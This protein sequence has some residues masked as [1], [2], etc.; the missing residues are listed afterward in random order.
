MLQTTLGDT[1][2]AGISSRIFVG[3]LLF[4]SACAGGGSTT[5]L[6]E[7]ETERAEQLEETEGDERAMVGTN[8]GEM[9]GWMPPNAEED[10]EM[11]TEPYPE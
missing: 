4:T 2:M 3:L 1:E 6:S 10:V 7:M 5:G 9:D 8:P 11:E